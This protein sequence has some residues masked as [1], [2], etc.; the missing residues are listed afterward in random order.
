M[1]FRFL[2]MSGSL[3]RIWLKLS[4]CGRGA[5]GGGGADL[6]AAREPASWRPDGLKGKAR[7]PGPAGPCGGR[8]PSGI[9]G[10]RET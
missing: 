4:S 10:P 6:H 2:M 1:R 3:W 7:R 9:G 8:G 5:L